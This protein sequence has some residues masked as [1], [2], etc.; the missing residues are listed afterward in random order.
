MKAGDLELPKEGEKDTRVL[1]AMM[2]GGVNV[3][4]PAIEQL[5]REML[6]VE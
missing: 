2:G 3:L 1:D 6:V 4:L 5:V